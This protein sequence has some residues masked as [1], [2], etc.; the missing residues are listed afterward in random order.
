MK[1]ENKNLLNKEIKALNKIDAPIVNF[2]EKY[3]Q[4]ID[5]QTA[6]KSL[7]LIG[8]CLDNLFAYKG[9]KIIQERVNKFFEETKSTLEQLQEEKIDKKYFDSDECFYIFQKIYEQIIRCDEKEK[10]N[11]FRNILI[12]SISINKSDVYHKERFINMVANLSI[13]HIKILKSYIDRE[14]VFKNEN[15]Q[16]NQCFT[17]LHSVY[18]KTGL[19]ESQAEAFCND[20]VRYD[21]LYDSMIGKYGYKR[22]HFRITNHAIEFMGFIENIE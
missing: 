4:N 14:I 2:S 19:T 8:G 3:C 18:Q 21:L 22:N 16:G 13:M 11:L 20:L 6:I 5:F 10:I 15:R 7:P 1:E 9:S 17:S 12:H